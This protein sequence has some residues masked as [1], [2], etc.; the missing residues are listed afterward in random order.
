VFAN[1]TAGPKNPLSQPLAI[2][3]ATFE[4]AR[5]ISGQ[6]VLSLIDWHLFPLGYPSDHTVGALQQF[7]QFAFFFY[8]GSLPKNPLES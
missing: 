1:S 7:G 3:S 2:G 5:P 6:S 8:L 4:E